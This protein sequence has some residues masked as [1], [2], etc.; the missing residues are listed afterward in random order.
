M[1][2]GR[3]MLHIDTHAALWLFQGNLDLFSKKAL[4]SMEKN[5]LI[6][7]AM[8]KLE[9][10]YL[11]EI[12]RC[13]VDAQDIFD[14]LHQQID[15]SISPLA[16]DAITEK[17]LKLQWTRDPFDRLIVANAMLDHAQLLTKDKHIHKHY[18]NSLW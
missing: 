16:L 10:Q 18:K 11:Y 1:G 17:A 14:T 8:V 9:I 6:I 4:Q 15:L 7:S 12:K 2:Q 3:V 5:K 13:V